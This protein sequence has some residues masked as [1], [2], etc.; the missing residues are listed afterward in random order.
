MRIVVLGA[1]P[2]GSGVALVRDALASPVARVTRLCPRCG[3]SRHGPVIATGVTPRHWVSVSHSP[4][5]T[6]V[7]LDTAGPVGVDIEP[8][9]RADAAVL[10]QWT[11][12]EAALKA[13]GRG[14]ADDPDSVRLLEGNWAGD[15]LLEVPG[16]ATPYRVRVT[17]V[18][19]AGHAA[20][21]AQ[22]IPALG[23]GRHTP[24][25]G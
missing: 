16:P 17:R 3:S 18:D 7:V 8:L 25:S 24:R 20:R 23:A 19:V 4:Q 5:A 15:C 11:A 14:L 22:L 6:V 12:T 1:T 13:T 9:D 21:V 2:Q 10:G